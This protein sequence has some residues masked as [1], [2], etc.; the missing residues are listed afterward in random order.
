M[1][2]TF[3][4]KN[5]SGNAAKALPITCRACGKPIK[6]GQPM[7]KLRHGRR[8]SYLCP[9]CNDK[10]ILIYQLDQ[11]KPKV[12][13]CLHWKPCKYTGDA[14]TTKYYACTKPTASCI[15]KFTATLDYIKTTKQKPWE[16]FKMKN[17]YLN[18]RISL[19]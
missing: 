1:L 11:Q 10:P 13:I 12:T 7:I 3:R 9:T 15:W 2:K 19:G 5:Y 17:K 14:V 8:T 6:D 16:L 18:Q 4:Q